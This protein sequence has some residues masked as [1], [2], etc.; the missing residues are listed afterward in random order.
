MLSFSGEDDIDAWII[1]DDQGS[2]FKSQAQRLRFLLCA[3]FLRLTPFFP[4][5]KL[6]VLQSSRKERQKR[7]RDGE[8][9]IH[10]FSV[11]RRAG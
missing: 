10:A 11:W 3:S 1:L 6:P 7:W 8:I 9:K 4:C 5:Y 2:D